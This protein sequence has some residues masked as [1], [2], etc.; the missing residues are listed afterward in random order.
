MLGILLIYFIGK[1][2][3]DLAL[4]RGKT[5][6]MQWVFAI[7]GVVIYYVGSF[8]GGMLLGILGYAFGWFDIETMNE[9]LISLMALPFGILASW[10]FYMIL[11]K[12]W[13]STDRETYIKDEDILDSNF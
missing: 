5:K 2:F 8:V 9:F 1:Y 6:T 12:S 4:E 3:Y 10:G 7:L 11:K 13:K